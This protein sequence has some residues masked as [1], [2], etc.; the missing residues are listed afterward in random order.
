MKIRLNKLIS[1]TIQNQPFT[2][3]ADSSAATVKGYFISVLGNGL[4]RF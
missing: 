4:E 3:K 2:V 1:K